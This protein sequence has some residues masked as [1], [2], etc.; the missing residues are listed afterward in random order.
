M[1]SRP[2]LALALEARKYLFRRENTHTF[3]ALK[4]DFGAIVGRKD[5]CDHRFG[6]V[7]KQNAPLGE[8]RKLFFP[9]YKSMIAHG[10]SHRVQRTHQHESKQRMDL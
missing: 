9:D 4:T 3:P 7:A 10:Q 6:P 1:R 2:K 8:R 5:G